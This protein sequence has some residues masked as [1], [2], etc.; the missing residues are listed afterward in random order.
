M[1]CVP[2]RES[3]WYFTRPAD[4]GET[5][6]VHSIK[7]ISMVLALLL[8]IWFKLG[9]VCCCFTLLCYEFA[10]SKHCWTRVSV[11]NIKPIALGKRYDVK[12]KMD[13]PDVLVIGYINKF[14]LREEVISD[15]A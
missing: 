8:S 10:Q 9:K 7:K 2:S 6:F 12:K 14:S 13:M 1:L 3:L 4:D 11:D 5:L 15:Q